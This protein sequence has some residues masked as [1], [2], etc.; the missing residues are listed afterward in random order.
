ML[1]VVNKAVSG[2][3]RPAVTVG[4]RPKRMNG[5]TLITWSRR[6][7]LQVDK[8]T[9]NQRLLSAWPQQFKARRRPWQFATA[10]MLEGLLVLRGA[11][12]RSRRSVKEAGNR[13][14]ELRR[15]INCPSRVDHDDKVR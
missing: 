10:L 13:A 9:L 8:S 12:T 2:F 11:G 1:V 5:G 15:R 4:P 6:N 7:S 14:A 3:Y